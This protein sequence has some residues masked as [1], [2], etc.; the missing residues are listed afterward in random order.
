[1]VCEDSLIKNK[2]A[3]FMWWNSLFQS[4]FCIVTFSSFPDLQALSHW[5]RGAGRR[6]GSG[7]RGRGWGEF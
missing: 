4:L 5:C 7:G 1:M 3:V 2:A 6:G